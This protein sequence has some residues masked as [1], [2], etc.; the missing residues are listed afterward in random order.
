MFQIAAIALLALT[1]PSDDFS[2]RLVL[3]CEAY[4]KNLVAIRDESGEIL[5]QQKT[6]RDGHHD[7]HLLENGNVLF[8]DGWTR[9]VE[10]T[11][12]KEVVWTYDAAKENGNE[13]RRV[14]VHAFE[15]LSDGRT[16]IAESGPARIIEVDAKGELLHTIP[17]TVEHPD[18]HRDTR[19]VR[20]T[21]TGHYLVCHEGDGKV[22]E[23]DRDGQVV[24]Q[25]DIGTPVYGAIELKSGNR[26]IASGGGSSILEVSPEGKVVWK[27]EGEV[28]GA[29]I[30]LKWTTTLRERDNGNLIIGNCHAGEDNPQIFEITKDKEVVW[31]MHDFEHFG[32]GVAA[33]EVLT[34]AQSRMVR[35]KLKDVPEAVRLNNDVLELGESQSAGSGR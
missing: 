11:L 17:L 33:T 30:A 32:N 4:G 12:S 27:L 13:G 26:L 6:R 10:M 18:A 8:Q 29:R 31:R 5:W 20:R 23:Y 22:R 3:I 21:K 14:E 25:Y 1:S 28:P 16:M 24:W 9:I 15:R 19:L 34:D 2:D 7:V 35:E